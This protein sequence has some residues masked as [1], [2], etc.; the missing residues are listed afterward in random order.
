[1]PR[2]NATDKAS[3]KVSLRPREIATVLCT[4]IDGAPP[5]PEPKNLDQFKNRVNVHASDAYASP[6]L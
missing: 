2:N 1:A 6:A 3:S 5:E 4:V